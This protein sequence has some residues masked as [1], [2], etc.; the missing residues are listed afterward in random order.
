MINGEVMFVDYVYIGKFEGVHGLKGEIKLRTDFKYVDRVFKRSFSFFVGDSKT[1]L[2]LKTYRKFK[3]K[4]LVSFDKRENIDA[5]KDFI[6]KKVYVRKSDLH[7]ES[8]QY[9]HED[10]FYKDCF[11]NDI[12]MGQITN[13]VDAGSGNYICYINGNSE[14]IIPL[15][16]HF[17]DKIEDDKIYFKNV[18]GLIDEN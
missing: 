16:D 5:I 4:Y 8:Y 1:Q 18:E 11:F 12:N 13:I 15:N 6:N 7:L 14:V 9:V 17:I 2:S 3:N 10:L